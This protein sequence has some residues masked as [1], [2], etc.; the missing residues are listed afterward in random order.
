MN[1]FEAG[2]EVTKNLAQAFVFIF[3]KDSEDHPKIEKRM[4]VLER[5]YQSRGLHVEVISLAGRSR[6]EKIF[7]AVLLGDWISCALAGLCGI[8]PEPVPMVEEF[9]MLIK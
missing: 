5:L 2:S 9:K 6:L 1:G 4:E 3:L 7:Q 8:D